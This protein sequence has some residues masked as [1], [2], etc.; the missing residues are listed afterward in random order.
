MAFLLAVLLTLGILS[1]AFIGDCKGYKKQENNNKIADQMFYALGVIIKTSKTLEW[2][3]KNDP[4][5]LRQATAAFEK[6]LDEYDKT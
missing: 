2:L 4:T 6:Y 3:E 5:S 1:L